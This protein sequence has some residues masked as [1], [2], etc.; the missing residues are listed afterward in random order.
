MLLGQR[1]IR[2]AHKMAMICDKKQYQHKQNM[3]LR[4]C[5]RNAVAVRMK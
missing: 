5:W 2:A 4:T 1:R 3:D